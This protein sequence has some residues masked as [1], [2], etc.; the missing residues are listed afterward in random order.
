MASE[1]DNIPDPADQDFSTP[2]QTA[3]GKTG[4]LLSGRLGVLLSILFFCTAGI[5][6][7]RQLFSPQTPDPPPIT[8]MCS[9]T[10]KTFQHVPKEGEKTPIVSPYTKNKTGYPV[11]KC[12][13][14]TADGKRKENPTYVILND[15][16]GKNGPTTCPSCGLMVYPHNTDYYNS[17]HSKP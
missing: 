4:G 13:C 16:L 10:M 8:Y 11:E 5:L 9:K 17:R 15:Q 12:Y 6:T 2:V 7:Y 1:P 14:W 3:H